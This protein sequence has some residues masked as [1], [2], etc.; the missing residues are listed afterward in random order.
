[1][2]Y[3]HVVDGVPSGRFGV[4]MSL[5][6]YRPV[7]L[8]LVLSLMPFWVFKTYTAQKC[9]KRRASLSV[10]MALQLSKEEADA[11]VESVY[12]TCHGDTSPYDRIP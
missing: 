12:D 3:C 6:T 8:S 11:A 4:I 10:A 1:M 9:V 7:F 2:R 5:W